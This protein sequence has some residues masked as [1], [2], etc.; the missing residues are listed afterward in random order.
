MRPGC[1]HQTIVFV[2]RRCM[3]TVMRAWNDYRVFHC[4]LPAFERLGVIDKYSYLFTETS[5]QTL[6]THTTNTEPLGYHQDWNRHTRIIAP[7]MSN[8]DKIKASDV[9]KANLEELAKSKG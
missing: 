4:L 1:S 3:N 8:S 5:H 2:H 6:H 7:D 9:T